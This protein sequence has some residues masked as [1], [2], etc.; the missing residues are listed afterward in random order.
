MSFMISLLILIVPII[1]KTTNIRVFGQTQ[2]TTS[3]GR[4]D[5]YPE[6]E[7]VY[8]NFSQAACLARGCLYD[9]SS[10]DILCYFKPNYGYI[11]QGNQETITNGIRLNLR[12]NQAVISPFPELIENITL[13]MTYYT[14]DIIRF[15]LYDANNSRYEV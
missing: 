7:S 12:R 5:C 1:G 14:N 3:I 15:K 9:N 4:I 6:S 13:D 2:T 10:S 11:L 8:S